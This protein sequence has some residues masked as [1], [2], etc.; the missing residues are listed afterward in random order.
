MIDQI[1]RF[2]LIC[3]MKRQPDLDSKHKQRSNKMA[4]K[5]NYNQDSI[6]MGLH[7]AAHSSKASVFLLF[8]TAHFLKTNNRSDSRAPLEGKLNKRLILSNRTTCT[9]MSGFGFA[10]HTTCPDNLGSRN[11]E[12]LKEPSFDIKLL[13]IFL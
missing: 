13:N 9:D 12:K 4:K 8:S 10:Q 2:F 5:I 7:K 11:S 3:S 1:L 6:Q